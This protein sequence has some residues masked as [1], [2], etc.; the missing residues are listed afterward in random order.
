MKTKNPIGLFD[1][2]HQLDRITPK[3]NFNYFKNMALILIM[4]DCF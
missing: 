4:L 3:K 1:L 2:R